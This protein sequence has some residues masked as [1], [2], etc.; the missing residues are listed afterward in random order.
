[1]WG[2]ALSSE[3]GL[4]PEFD[5]DNSQLRVGD[6]F[7]RFSIEFSCLWIKLS[8]VGLNVSELNE[9]SF[10]IFVTSIRRQRIENGVIWSYEVK[11]IRVQ[12]L[13][14]SYKIFH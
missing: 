2:R 1:M 13:K 8:K 14:G 11:V 10:K 3:W 9:T 12:R 6:D 7:D 4:N 5:C